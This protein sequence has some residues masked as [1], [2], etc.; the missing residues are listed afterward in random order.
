MQLFRMQVFFA[1]KKTTFT[2]F[3]NTVH[4]VGHNILFTSISL[5]NETKY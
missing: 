2:V 1:N 3:I 5:M 4:F